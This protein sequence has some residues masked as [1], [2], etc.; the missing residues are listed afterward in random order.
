AQHRS[1]LD[2][3][4]EIFGCVPRFDLGL[5]KPNQGLAD[6]TGRVLSGVTDVIRDFRPDWVLVQGDT[7][8][9]F[10]AALAAFYEKVNVGHVEAG[11]RTGLKYSPWP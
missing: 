8:T 9:A 10:G 2:Q 7:T 1:M 4:L 6:V 3:V 5:M 11:L